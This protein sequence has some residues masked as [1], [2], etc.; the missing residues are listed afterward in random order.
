M[1][2]VC[3]YCDFQDREKQTA[4]DMIGALTRQLVNALRFV[5]T[6]IQEAFKRAER[7]V[8][9]RGLKVSE[10]VM[11]LRTALAPVRR[12]FILIDALDECPDKHLFELLTSLRT[13]SQG[14]P[15]IRIFITG[16]PHIR[17]MVEKHFP[18]G[19]QVIPISPNSEDI[20]VYL[21]RALERDLDSE[22][23]NPALKADIVKRIPE[24]IPGAYVMASLPPKA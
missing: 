2:V 10:A 13:I 8:G 1:A 12:T 23:M 24:R 3:L 20:R 18:R 21:E 6:K 5:P 16:R 22:T 14:S 7:E 17:S 11:L 4:T 19:M 9:G 15:D